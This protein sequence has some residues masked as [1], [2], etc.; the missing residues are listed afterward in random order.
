LTLADH[1][2]VGHYSILDA[3]GGLDIGEGV[4]IGVG[5][6]IYSHGSQN[7]IRLLGKSYVDTQESERVGYVRAPVSIGKY[8][9]IGSGAVVLPGVRIG[10]GAIIG[11]NAVVSTDVPDHS[12]WM[13]P[14][15]RAVG[16][17][18]AGDMA[19]A[20]SVGKLPHYYAPEILRQNASESKL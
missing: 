10:S 15:T 19:V 11:P 16:E 1:I 8:S 17:T 18:T 9:F 20:Q 7:A 6:C 3:T 5:V 2:W 4:Q 12:I 13:L 14:P